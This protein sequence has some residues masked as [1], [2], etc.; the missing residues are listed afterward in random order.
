MSDNKQ[1]IEVDFLTSYAIGGVSTQ[2]SADSD[3]WVNKYE[4][5][6][7]NDGQQFY[8]VPDSPGGDTARVFYGNFDRNSP[9]MHLFHLVHARYIRV[10]PIEFHG[11]IA[12]RWVHCHCLCSFP[13][14]VGF[15]SFCL[16][17]FG[18]V[19]LCGSGEEKKG[20]A[21]ILGYDLRG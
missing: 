8:P 6:Y 5:F 16:L 3:N 13:G 1:W 4:V 19:S 14:H 20:F 21:L 2:G 18:S 10:R 17:L 12:L 11:A 15:F 7:S 9:V